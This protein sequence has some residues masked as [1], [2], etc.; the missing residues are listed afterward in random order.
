MIEEKQK[1][2]FFI[3]GVGRSGTSLLQQIMNTYSGFCNKKESKVGGDFSN[4]CWTLV[5]KSNDFSHLEKFIEKNWISEYFI[6]KTPDSILCIPEAIHRFPKANYIFLERDPKKIVLSQLNLYS[7][8]SNDFL[9]RQYHIQNLIT[10][11]EDFFLN[12]EQYWAKLTLN[13]VRLMITNKKLITNNVTIKYENL[14]DSLKSNLELF[15]R[16]FS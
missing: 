7:S 10:S 1:K 15:F 14:I 11:K 13:Q 16:K 2:L 6:E 4:S 12:S 8:Q 3:I 9:E 5:R